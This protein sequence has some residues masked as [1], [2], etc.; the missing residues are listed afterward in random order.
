MRALHD[1]IVAQ[2][3]LDDLLDALSCV[4]TGDTDIRELIIVSFV[5]HLPDPGEP[6]A[7]IRELLPAAL[8]Q[9]ARQGVDPPTEPEKWSGV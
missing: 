4:H 2:S 7:A 8:Q 1:R 3:L 5:E 9:A 6:N